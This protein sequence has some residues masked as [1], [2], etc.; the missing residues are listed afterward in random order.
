MCL[1]RE[2]DS[3]G[4][5]GARKGLCVDMMVTKQGTRSD[6]QE[7]K[8]MKRNKNRGEERSTSHVQHNTAKRSTYH[9]STDVQ[10][11]QQSFCFIPQ[12][13]VSHSLQAVSQSGR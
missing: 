11:S 7:D 12:S 1:D 10:R 4:S 8:D 9:P 13:A 6:A 2:E 5:F 3:T